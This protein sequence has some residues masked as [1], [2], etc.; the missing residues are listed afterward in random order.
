MHALTAAAATIW[1]PLLRVTDLLPF[2]EIFRDF[3]PFPFDDFTIHSPLESLTTRT[4]DG[5]DRRR[6]EDTS[7][8]GDDRVAPDSPGFQ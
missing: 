4:R 2:A 5:T 7:A 8:R 6:A 3:R 1:S